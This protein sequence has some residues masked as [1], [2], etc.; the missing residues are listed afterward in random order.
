MPEFKNYAPFLQSAQPALPSVGLASV[1]HL[2]PSL[3]HEASL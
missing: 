1:P 3:Q 2:P